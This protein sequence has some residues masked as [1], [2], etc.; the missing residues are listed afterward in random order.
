MFGIIICCLRWGRVFN[1]EQIQERELTS[2]DP[3][4]PEPQHPRVAWR[5]ICSG[6][7]SASSRTP[8][9]RTLKSPF[10]P[11]WWRGGLN[12]FPYYLPATTA[13]CQ[14]INKP[15]QQ[16]NE[17]PLVC[18]LRAILSSSSSYYSCYNKIFP[19]PHLSCCPPPLDAPS[20][21]SPSSALTK[22]C[23]AYD[24]IKYFSVSQRAV[25][26]FSN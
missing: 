18:V 12:S 19:P 10:A 20:S 4:R 9:A 26:R 6:E 21:S 7:P 1:C 2:W 23:V 8:P 5:C 3:L 17:A 14:S 11:S 24:P 15:T 13:T 16:K 25:Y 22:P